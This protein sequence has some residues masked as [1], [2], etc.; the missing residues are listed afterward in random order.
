VSNNVRPRPSPRPMSERIHFSDNVHLQRRS[1]S[2]RRWIDL[3]HDEHSQT[4]KR[5]IHTARSWI[6]SYLVQQ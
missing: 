4:A 2:R 5:E 6:W 3:V 1:F